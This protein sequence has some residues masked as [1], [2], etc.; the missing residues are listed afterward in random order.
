MTKYKNRTFSRMEIASFVALFSLSDKT[1][2]RVIVHFLP[3]SLLPFWSKKIHANSFNLKGIINHS[4]NNILKEG[5]RQLDKESPLCY[6]Y[7]NF[8]FC[9]KP[10][11]S[12]ENE[13]IQTKGH[14]KRLHSFGMPFHLGMFSPKQ[15]K[16]HTKRLHPHK[17]GENERIQPTNERASKR[18]HKLTI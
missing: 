13:R 11:F 8:S 10:N 7:T 12:R 15:I 5:K 18:S 14:T 16:G 17:V 6:K 3:H 1:K 2:E 4:D 9:K